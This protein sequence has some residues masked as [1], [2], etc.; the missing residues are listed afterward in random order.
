MPDAPVTTETS[1]G[2]VL[3]AGATG[4]LGG[5]IARELLGA[6]FRVRALGRN[7]DKLAALA[8]LGAEPV[9]ADLRDDAAVRAACSGAAQVV[10]SANNVMGTGAASPTRVDLAAHVS[11]CRAAR[12]AGVTR[13]V[14]VSGRGLG[15]VP[16]PVDFF[17]VKQQIDALI[18]GSGIPY[19]LLQPSA[20]ME[21]WVALVGDGIRDKGVATLFGSGTRRANFIAVADV[22]RFARAILERP[23][24][25]NEAIEVGGPSNLSYEALAGIIERQ[26]GVTAKRTH[27][28]VPVLR[29][30]SRLLRPVSEK[31]GRMMAL[32]Y[33]SAT[34]DADFP[35][36]KRAAERFGVEP[37][38]VEEFVAER[39][40]RAANV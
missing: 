14:N 38:Q 8:A 37:R 12:A 10:T 18:V 7:A 16:S 28:P 26:L 11:L 3:V 2:I 40:G 35:G 39:Y 1:Q 19:V 33:F 32:G 9:G 17:H 24:V 20:F 36:W 30:G 29:W 6:G 25:V 27:V 15:P 13:L 4:V 21:T 5:A 31:T 34:H 22:A 23:E